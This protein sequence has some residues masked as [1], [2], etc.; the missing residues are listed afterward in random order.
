[1]A[2]SKGRFT[3]GKTAVD[4]VMPEPFNC[5]FSLFPLKPTI[6]V[7]WSK[8]AGYSVKGF[9]NYGGKT[10]TTLDIDPEAVLKA[11]IWLASKIVAGWQGLEV[12]GPDGELENMPYSEE[13]RNHLAAED[14]LFKIIAD[15]A[16]KLAGREVEEEEKN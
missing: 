6:R 7:K 2:I 10:E 9:A 16:S 5:I 15:E 13:A 4:V 1:M 12:I 14:D 8:M 11:N 3:D